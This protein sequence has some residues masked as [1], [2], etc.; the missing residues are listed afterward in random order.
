MPIL[1]DLTGRR[2]GRLTVTGALRRDSNY[3]WYW[4]CVCDCGS[5]TVVQGASLKSGDIKSCG[6]LKRE[7]DSARLKARL[8]THG[9][10]A[11]QTRSAEYRCWLAMRDRCLSPSY[12]R[13]PDYGGRGITICERWMKFDNFLEDMGRKPDP[14]LTIERIDNDGNYEPGNCKWATRLEQAKNKRPRKKKPR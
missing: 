8:T 4:N 10:S 12:K 2:F 1:Q 9:E 6:C 11:G 5:E 14:S 3:N 13:Y 7:V